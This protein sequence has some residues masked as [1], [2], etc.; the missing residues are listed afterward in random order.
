MVINGLKTIGPD[1]LVG[2]KIKSVR[3]GNEKLNQRMLDGKPRN[4]YGVIT[5]TMEN[6]KEFI[7]ST[8]MFAD[9]LAF[10]ERV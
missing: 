2:G 9:E 1:G 7:I 8:N 5:L 10:R 6:G 3:Y 4:T